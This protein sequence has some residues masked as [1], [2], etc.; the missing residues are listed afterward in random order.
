VSDDE[1]LRKIVVETLDAEGLA[2]ENP[3]E[4]RWFVTLPGV[5]KLRTNC[6]LVLDRHAMTVEAFVCRRPDEATDAVHRFLLRRNA[7]LYGVHYT[8]DR[9]GDIHLVGRISRHAVCA[10]ELDRVLG[11]VL[12]AADGDFNRLLEIGFAGAIRREWE[13]RISRGESVANLTAF[14]HL[15][16]PAGPASGPRTES[17]PVP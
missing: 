14:E 7:R 11:Q 12:E 5:T 1:T 9:V 8:I 3:A 4:G 10:E 6:W 16:G 13:W 15:T 2:Y 17:G